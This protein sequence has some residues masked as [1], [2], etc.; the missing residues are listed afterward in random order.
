[1]PNDEC[2]YGEDLGRPLFTI[3]LKKGI[4]RFGIGK[5]CMI[6]KYIDE[7]REFVDMYSTPKDKRRNGM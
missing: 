4:F 6:L 5:A 7:I 3:K 1:M 2:Y